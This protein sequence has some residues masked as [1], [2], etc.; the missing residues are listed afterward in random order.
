MREYRVTTAYSL[1]AVEHRGDSRAFSKVGLEVVAL[2]FHVCAA[3]EALIGS[4]STT[5]QLFQYF[6]S[7]VERVGDRDHCDWL[8][9]LENKSKLMKFKG[10][11]EGFLFYIFI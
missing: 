7:S 4:P 11:T 3:P 6:D 10:Y 2:V 9:S 5:F 1:K 8:I